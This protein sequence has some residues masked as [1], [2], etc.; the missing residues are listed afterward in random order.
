MA[1]PFDTH[2]AIEDLVATGLTPE[3]AKAIV[4]T[5]VASNP[6]AVT[7]GD[8]KATSAASGTNPR[9]EAQSGVGEELRARFALRERRILL[10]M[11]VIA[12][13]LFIAL[14]LTG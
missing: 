7:R 3:Q 14:R 2:A 8:S 10:G 1:C 6:G 12:G 11:L 13:L 9:S 5:I 4:A